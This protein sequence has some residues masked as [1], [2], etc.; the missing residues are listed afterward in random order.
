MT[1]IRSGLAAL[2]AVVLV[3]A[4]FAGAAVAAM[5]DQQLVQARVAAMKQ[6]GQILRGAKDLSGDKAIAAASTILKNFK[7][8]PGLFRE[9]SITPD[10]RATEKIWQNW[11][12][13]TKRLKAEE[14]NA[15]AMLAAA[16]AGDKKA[17]LAAIEAL[18]KPCSNCHLAYARVF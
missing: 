9:G 2:L 15:E 3:A 12:D 8:F 13:F 5:S 6:D 17:Y 1:R 7:S 14:R 18:K 16:K 10:S 11:A 4:V